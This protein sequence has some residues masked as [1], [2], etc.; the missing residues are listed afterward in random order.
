MSDT[1]VL[2]SLLIGLVIVC[3]TLYKLVDRILRHSELIKGVRVVDDFSKIQLSI[4]GSD[5][6]N[7]EE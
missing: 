5:D 3:F 1:N 6:E 2:I 7:E 4:G